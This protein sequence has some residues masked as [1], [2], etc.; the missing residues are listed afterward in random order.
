MAKIKRDAHSLETIRGGGIVGVM[1]AVSFIV[2]I[3]MLVISIREKES[4]LFIPTVLFGTPGFF[5]LFGRL[6]TK[7]DLQHQQVVRWFGLL[8]PMFRTTYSMDDF[9][10]V[11]VTRASAG[12]N[13]SKIV[14]PVFLRR[15]ETEDEK[16]R[17][18]ELAKALAHLRN[19]NF[20]INNDYLPSRALAESIAR[21][22]GM[23][24]HDDSS[25]EMIIRTPDE[26]DETLRDR[27]MK[28]GV[29]DELPDAPEKTGVRVLTDG[30]SMT[31]EFPAPGFQ[32][33][34]MLVMVMS[35]GFCVTAA[36][37]AFLVKSN[38]T[39]SGGGILIG[40]FS[41]VG[42]LPFVFTF[43]LSRKFARTRETLTLTGEGDLV[44]ERRYLSSA[45]TTIPAN[46]LEELFVRHPERQP[47]LGMSMSKVYARSD[48]ES[49]EFGTGSSAAELDWIV[50]V[51][52]Y[53]VVTTV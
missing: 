24:F 1:G 45:S 12:Q 14:Y 29:P 44:L 7:I 50:A 34:H 49:L 42:L 52:E 2:G 51:I 48:K 22:L 36:C 39:S 37:M 47:I 41:V 19:L 43:T 31:F 32:A 21:M 23:E 53:R 28:R 25:G 46:E 8:V 17:D 40:V 27:L 30:D 35:L 10:Y 6:G 16:Q 18:E 26:F 33:V 15:K 5:M 3:A 20:Q 11:G 13:N 38:L 9:E 4:V